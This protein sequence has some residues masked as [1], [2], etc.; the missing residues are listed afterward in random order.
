MCF[1]ETE[2]KP[3]TGI[4]EVKD[5]YGYGEDADEDGE[6]ELPRTVRV[7][8]S[9]WRYRVET[10]G[11]DVL[12]IQGTDRSW[13]FRPGSSTRLVTDD[14][15]AC[16]SYGYAIER[17][18]PPGGAA[19]TSRPGRPDA[20]HDVPRSRRLGGRARPATT[21]AGPGEAGRGRRDRD[22]AAVGNVDQAGT[23]SPG[24]RST[25]TSS[26]SDA[27]FV[28]DGPFVFAHGGDGEDLPDDLRESLERARKPR[29][30]LR[31]SALPGLPELDLRLSAR[32]DVWEVGDDGCSGGDRLRGV[33]VA[34]APAARG[35][36]GG[37]RR[38]PRPSVAWTQDGWDWRLACMRRRSRRPTSSRI[39]R[40]LAEPRPDQGRD[41]LLV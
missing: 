14:E 32:P 35:G 36:A 18:A 20:P 5:R 29:R 37:R 30:A 41:P 10:L 12:F 40:Q 34:Q 8:K 23:T 6:T 26:S 13:L 31:A 17:P 39:R 11:G 24:P 27:L 4:V 7:H 33:P 3:F 38:R 15:E 16:G 22:A 19:T 25:M 9:G 21:Q 1:G 28:W 2:E